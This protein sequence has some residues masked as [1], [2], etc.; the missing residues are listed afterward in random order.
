MTLV[1]AAIFRGGARSLGPQEDPHAGRTGPSLLGPASC[2]MKLP[3]RAAEDR[4]SSP[5]RYTRD[6][7]PPLPTATELGVPARAS[8]SSGLPDHLIIL[9]V[10]SRY[11]RCM[12]PLYISGKY[13]YY[14]R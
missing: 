1:V 8:G 3:E 5:S 11:F 12:P 10:G 4:R 6:R 7:R 2:G 9:Y 13:I 14:I